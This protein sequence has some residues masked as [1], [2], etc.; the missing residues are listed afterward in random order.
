DYLGALWAVGLRQRASTD[1]TVEQALADRTIVRT[2]P[3]RGTLH[4]VAAEDVHWMV[5]LLAPRVAAGSSARHRELELDARVF[6][7]S[8]ELFVDALHGGKQVTRPRLYEILNA[9][10][11]ATAGARGLHILGHHAQTRLICFAAREGKQQAFA[12][13]DEWVPP[14]KAKERDEALAELA[15]RYFTGHGPAT[16]HDFAWWSGLTLTDARAGA[17]LAKPRLTTAS[18]DDRAHWFAGSPPAS[19]ASVDRAYLL[20]AFDEYTVAYRDRSAVLDPSYA[21]RVNAGGGIFNPI[22]VLGGQ[23]VGTWKRTLT[24]TSVDVTF[25]PFKRLTKAQREAFDTAADRYARFLKA[26]RRQGGK[27]R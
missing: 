13:L 14:P 23:V 7:R 18:I 24:K 2:W 17:E 25:M 15:A 21:K 27:T 1:A 20:P 8:G 22:M 12:L 10:N 3:M 19:R 4:F 9:A 16:L 5:K 11:I 6:A 26:A